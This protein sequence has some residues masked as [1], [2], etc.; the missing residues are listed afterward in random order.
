MPHLH[1]LYN[2]NAIHA[3]VDLN[4]FLFFFQKEHGNEASVAAVSK[5]MPKKVKKRK[6]ITTEAGVHHIVSREFFSNASYRVPIVIFFWAGMY[7]E[8][9]CNNFTT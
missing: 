9:R 6:K 2:A 3:F 7:P 1:Y 5:Q 4:C 8:T